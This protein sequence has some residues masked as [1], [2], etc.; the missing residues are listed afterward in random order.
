[1]LPVRE[2]DLELVPLFLALF[3]SLD[4]VYFYIKT[5]L[6]GCFEGILYKCFASGGDRKAQKTTK[7]IW[8]PILLTIFWVLWNERNKR[9]FEEETSLQQPKINCS[10]LLFVWS[11]PE[12]VEDTHQLIIFSSSLSS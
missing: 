10:F 9:C 8:N 5:I 6:H 1:M 11:R 3:S 4:G 12:V 2:K 7:K